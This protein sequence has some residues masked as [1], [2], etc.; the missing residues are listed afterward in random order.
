MILTTT[1][2]IEGRRIVAYKGIACGE[3]IIGAHLGKDI[4]ASFTNLVGG[5]SESYE[6][7]IRETRNDA[8]GEMVEGAQKLGANAIVG[9]KFDY[10]VV[11][12]QG[13]MMMVAVSGTAVVLE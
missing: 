6:S 3:V 9:V 8:L 2:S 7:T 12:Q 4:L 11:G 13:S 10:G 5:R 1:S